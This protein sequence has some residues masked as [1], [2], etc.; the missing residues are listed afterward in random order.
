MKKSALKY[1]CKTSIGSIERGESNP[2]IE[3]LK[4]I[5]LALNMELKELVDVSNFNL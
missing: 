4:R 5:A 3:T 1:V 2:S